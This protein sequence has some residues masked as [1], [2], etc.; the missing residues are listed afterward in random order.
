MKRIGWAALAGVGALSAAGAAQAH[1][2]YMLPNMFDLTERG[3]VTVQASFAEDAF[4]PEVAMRSEAFHTRGPDGA[5]LPIKDVVYLRDLTVFEAA[6]P[7]NGTYRI[8]S[9]ERFGRKGKMYRD[10]AGRWV[11]TGEGGERPAGAELVDVQSLTLA[12]VY[13]SRGAPTREALAVTGKGLEVRPITHPSEIFAAQ[14]AAFELLFDGAPVA[15]AEVEVYRS[16]GLY[17]GRKKIA[18]RIVTDA[19]GR[20]SIVPPDGG[21][22]LALIRHRTAAPAGA[23]TPYRSYSYTLTFEATE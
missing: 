8:S 17:D 9:G 1:M 6:V 12:E 4:V 23:E 10:A 22:Y 13:V 19:A 18:D 3:H 5:A 16:A 20:F 7:A 21:T 11:M 2:P 14:P 15:G